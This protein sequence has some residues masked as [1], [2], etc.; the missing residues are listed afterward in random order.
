LIANSAR[1]LRR[2][3]PTSPGRFKALTAV[4]VLGPGTPMRFQ[5]QEVVN[6]G[7]DLPMAPAPEPLL[8]PSQDRG[9]TILQYSE[10]QRYGGSGTA[11]L[12]GVVNWHMPGHA[13]VVMRPKTSPL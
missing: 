10:D 13:A 3:R 11:A 8:A 6:L 9:W 5:G 2:H 7:R 1:G 4:M 12:E